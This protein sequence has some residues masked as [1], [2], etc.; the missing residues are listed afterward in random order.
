MSQQRIQNQRPGSGEHGILISQHEQRANA[1]SLSTLASN[2]DCQP[3]HRLK[4]AGIV[5][6]YFAENTFK[7]ASRSS[8]GVNSSLTSSS[9]RG[10][11]VTT[12]QSLT[13]YAISAACP[14]SVSFFAEN[15]TSNPL[16]ITYSTGIKKRLR[17]V[18]N[19]MPPTIAVPTE[20]R[21][22]LPAP[23]AK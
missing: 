14:V 2:F 16:T 8:R 9:S 12:N 3:N 19:N 17:M 15:E 4:N 23:V 6:R 5:F 20:C 21:P 13:N 18:E 11:P 1:S 22:S 10:N 7:H